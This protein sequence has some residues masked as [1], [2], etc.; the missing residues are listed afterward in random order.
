MNLLWILLA[1]QLS[2]TKFAESHF[3]RVENIVIK[4]QTF[5]PPPTLE[6]SQVKIEIRHLNEVQSDWIDGKKEIW[7]NGKR[8]RLSVEEMNQAARNTK[9][10]LE[11]ILTENS[12][13]I[14][15]YLWR[16][17]III[18]P[19][20]S[21]QSY[22]VITLNAEYGA[23]LNEKKM[24]PEIYQEK[25]NQLRSLFVHEQIHQFV[26][27]NDSNENPRVARLI[28]ELKGTIPALAK[29]PVPP[30]LTK[31]LGAEGGRSATDLHIIVNW[32]AYQANKRL[33]ESS[34]AAAEL[35]LSTGIYNDIYRAVIENDQ[36]IAK[37]IRKPE[38]L[39]F[40]KEPK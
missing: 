27:P 1:K 6:R 32:M 23:S 16:K 33:L 9:R 10:L 29:I 36:L 38:Y 12:P 34:K 14:S 2:E 21:S 20:N 22:P 8:A 4:E 30:R 25:K 11:E 31:L 24:A 19:L 18:D 39:S 37:I 7:I 5:F 3:L 26:G 17:S 28:K 35:L 40:L 15:Q 13:D